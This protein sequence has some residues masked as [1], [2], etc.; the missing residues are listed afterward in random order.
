MILIAEWD[1]DLARTA[2]RIVSGRD[3][4]E[5]GIAMSAASVAIDRICPTCGS[6]NGCGMANGEATC[7]CFA[8]PHVVSV[9]QEEEPGRC[10]CRTCLERVNDGLATRAASSPR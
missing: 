5:E 3:I 2:A 8:L 4:A 6:A 10:Y 9:S 1:L 7:W